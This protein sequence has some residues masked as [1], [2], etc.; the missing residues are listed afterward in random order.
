MIIIYNKSVVIIS[1]EEFKGH[2]RYKIYM[3]NIQ[4]LVKTLAWGYR[5][6]EKKIK[7]QVFI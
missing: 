1:I 7:A 6:N 4:T 5:Y 2:S 3:K